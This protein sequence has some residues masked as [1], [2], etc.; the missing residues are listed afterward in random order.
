M[1]DAVDVDGGSKISYEEFLAAALQLSKVCTQTEDGDR[2]DS[3]GC[4]IYGYTY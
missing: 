4:R 1:F 2:S 3:D